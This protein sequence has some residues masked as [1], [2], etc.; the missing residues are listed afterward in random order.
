MEI[1]I[2]VLRFEWNYLFQDIGNLSI[3][4]PI[5]KAYISALLHSQEQTLLRLVGKSTAAR[6]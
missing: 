6:I 3:S 5:V 1:Q 2:G 4:I